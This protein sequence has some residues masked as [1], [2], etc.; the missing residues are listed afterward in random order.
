M[1]PGLLAQLFR[2]KRIGALFGI[3]ILVVPATLLF[4]GL[5]LVWA[6][7]AAGIAGFGAAAA[8]LAV[9][10]AS[11]LAHELAHAMVA[12]RLGLQVLDITFQ[13]LGGMARLSGMG[14]RAWVE[15]PVALAGPVA[16]LALG[17]VALLLPGV[18]AG[19]AAML[20]LVLGVG[21][22]LPSFPLDGGRVLRAFLAR[23]S[24]VPDATW[25]AVRFGS[26]VALAVFAAATMLGAF[27]PGLLLAVYL[28][29]MG[30]LELVQIFLRGGGTP[31][32][33]PGEVFARAFRRG[34][35]AA[36]PTDLGGH[37]R[38]HEAPEVEAV[39]EKHDLEDFHGTLEEW[40][41]RKA[42]DGGKSGGPGG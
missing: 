3:P 30:K 36:T 21:N 34:P 16:N 10:V 35:G 25:A 19:Q 18:L 13:P 29:S 14:A 37:A 26:W 15:G 27:L 24:P 4:F 38:A 28:W 42:Q 40:F 7:Q 1:E 12:R 31:T 9:L 6:G 23:R 32:L 41:R 39:A 22:L 2:P 17:G 33:R 20:N 8:L 11:L 5:L